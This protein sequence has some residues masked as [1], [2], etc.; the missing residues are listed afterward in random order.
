M[1]AG[2]EHKGTTCINL[3]V[4]NQKVAT[5]TG[6]SSDM[7]K[8][9]SWE[10]SQ[11]KGKTAYI[12]IVDQET[13]GFGHI[14]V[15]HIVFSDEPVK[16]IKPKIKV[17]GQNRNKV[18]REKD[19]CS[20]LMTIDRKKYDDDKAGAEKFCAATGIDKLHYDGA[21]G[22]MTLMAVSGDGQGIASWGD[23]E[24]LHKN[25]LNNSQMAGPGTIGPSEQGKTYN[26]ALSVPFTLKPSQ[27][28]TVTFILTWYFPNASNGQNDGKWDFKGNMYS[29]W[30]TNSKDVARYVKD[31]LKDLSAKTHLYHDTFYK[32][33]LPHWLLD[34][35]S[36]QV[37]ILDSKTFFW[38][39]DGYFGCFEGC[40]RQGGCCQG[41]CSHVYPL[42]PIAGLSISFSGEKNA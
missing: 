33:N 29:N 38:A 9:H 36:S 4:D 27:S 3:L 40:G 24:E 35:V 21:L 19:N 20:L 17:L 37:A 23:I 42:C 25:W 28:K 14:D 8:W 5:A 1:I 26:G 30:W 12:E 15:D 10:V 31:N 2:G 22:S 11:F 32:S 34:R 13:G 18:V 6:R 16:T 7:L 39:K 41:N